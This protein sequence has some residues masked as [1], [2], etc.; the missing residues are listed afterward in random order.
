MV[1]D[2]NGNK[3]CDEIASEGQAE[4]GEEAENTEGPCQEQHHR[5]PT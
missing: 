2:I 3:K 5:D 4:T 1:T